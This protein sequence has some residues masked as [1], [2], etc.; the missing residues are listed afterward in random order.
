MVVPALAGREP[1]R[2]GA[3]LALAAAPNVVARNHKG[4]LQSTLEAEHTR[5]CEEQGNGGA[6]GAGTCGAIAARPAVGG[7]VSSTMQKTSQPE[8]TEAGRRT[9]AC[10][11]RR[12]RGNFPRNRHVSATPLVNPFASPPRLMLTVGQRQPVSLPRSVCR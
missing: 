9:N 11:R 1:L 6:R 2:I 3:P 12:K 5:L 10:S 7:R 4:Q 8:Q